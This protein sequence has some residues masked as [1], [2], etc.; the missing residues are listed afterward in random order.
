MQ[1]FSTRPEIREMERVYVRE[2]PGGGF[3]A[4]EITPMRNFLGRR[5]YHGEVV[6]ERR[7][8][9]ERREGH[10]A[11]RVAESE[12]ATISSVLHQLFPVA[13]SNVAV[14]ARC[15]AQNRASRI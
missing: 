5:K 2:L 6:V 13:Q 4:I 14:A 3:V 7:S 1:R 11:P 15:L 12:A 9:L 10:A 8:D